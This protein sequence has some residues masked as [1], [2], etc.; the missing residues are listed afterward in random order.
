MSD[1]QVPALVEPDMAARPIV[2]LTRQA[3]ANWI[4]GQPRSVTRFIDACGFDAEP[5]AFTHLPDAD[6]TILLGLGD[7]P[8]RWSFAGLPLALPE[9][10]Y[11]V[12]DEASPTTTALAWALGA[13]QFS[14]YRHPQRQAARL[15]WPDRA[16][17][18]AVARAWRA[19]LL[20]RDTINTPA[21]DMGPADLADVIDALA[22]EHGGHCSV[23][24][25][26]S[27]LGENY[28]L[29]HAVGRAAGS[30]GP[31]APRLIDMVWGEE[32]APKLTLVGKGVCFDTGGLDLKISGKMMLMK[33]DMGGAAHALALASMVMDA[34]LPVRLRLLI[35]A[36]ENAI[37]PG[38]IRPLDV[39]RA[40]NGLTVEIAN[41]DAEGRLIL[42]DALAEAA[43]EAPEL[44]L[45]FATLTSASMV[46]LG[47]DIAAMFSNDDGV[48]AELLEAA[49]RANDPIHRLP[50]WQPYAQ[51]LKGKTGEIT[52][53]ADLN[54]GPT[55]F[56]GAIYAALFLE[57]FVGNRSPWVHFDLATWN[58]RA[59]PGRPEGGEMKV[60]L[61]V[62]QYLQKR[63]S[64]D[65]SAERFPSHRPAP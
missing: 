6:R 32:N 35:P 14:R 11:R 49:Q 50:L 29:I 47:P 18:R 23:I 62:F 43:T 24:V 38:A 48:S 13:Y 27:L 30:D 57:R 37:G 61:G 53:V 4:A 63:F 15:C 17:R 2:A 25:G 19:A 16:D 41:T 45:D 20:V 33:L 40:R 52:N 42:A 55:T 58:F 8:D 3:L 21:G 12:A 59:R 51:D 26:D 1:S 34:N 39:V 10:V 54:L 60:L 7:A 64:E 22:R 28:P 36:V 44:I 9:G 46:A 56:A 5:H 65:R 31:R